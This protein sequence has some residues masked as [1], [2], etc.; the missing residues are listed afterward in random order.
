MII[1]EGVTKVAGAG[2]KKRGLLTAVQAVLPSDRRIAIFAQTEQDKKLFID[3]LA[4]LV[5]PSAGR[6]VR[7][8]QVS[9]PPGYLGGFTRGLTVRV[10]VAHVARIYGADV[11]TVVDFVSQVSSLGKDFNKL[12]G[13]LP[14]PKKR[15]LSDILAFSIP[16][17]AYLLGEDV[18]R[19]GSARY[20]KEA[21]ALFEARCKTSGMFIASE[22]EAFAREFC[23]M[24]LVLNDG[25]LRLFRNVERAIAFSEKAAED[26]GRSR[27]ERRGARKRKRKKQR[28]AHDQS[29]K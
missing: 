2:Q 19:P 28:L 27:E 9:F 18:V 15:Y 14:N 23:D 29:Q 11:E 16:F 4:G 20:N 8:A 1:F 6:I 17:D 26:P 12:Y 10:N 3:L 21:R 7:K 24:G 22:D 25:N 5:L 13:D